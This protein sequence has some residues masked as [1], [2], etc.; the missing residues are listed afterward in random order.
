MGII[1]TD[2]GLEYHPEATSDKPQK[3]RKKNTKTSIAERRVEMVVQ[4]LNYKNQRETQI[5]ANKQT[6][7]KF[8]KRGRC[9]KKDCEF[10]HEGP[11]PLCYNMLKDGVCHE[12]DHECCY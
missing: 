9:T 2:S 5:K 10:L 4:F 7:C 12:G 8:Y 11:P 3:K 1:Q 6:V